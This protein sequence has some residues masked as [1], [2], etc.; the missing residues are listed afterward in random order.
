[1]THAG[2][3]LKLCTVN[4]NSDDIYGTAYLCR[5]PL[6]HVRACTPQP[7]NQTL[8]RHDVITIYSNN[9]CR[10]GLRLCIVTKNSDDILTR[11]CLGRYPLPRTCLSRYPHPHL[12]N[13]KALTPSPLL[14]I[15]PCL[16]ITSF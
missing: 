15:K 9:S 2:C 4:K 12:E 8:S 1:M 11:A 6:E 14:S 3:G 10:C 13:V 16:D 5:T 7:V